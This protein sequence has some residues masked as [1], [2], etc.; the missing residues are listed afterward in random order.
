MSEV[1]SFTVNWHGDQVL[2]NVRT[3]TKYGMDSVMADCVV[4]AK[5]E[6]AWQNRTTILQG[7]I[8]MR[9]AVDSGNDITGYWGAFANN[10]AIFLEEGTARIPKGKYTWLAPAAGKHYPHLSE[11]I[12]AK[13]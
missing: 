10:Y 8:A 4:T 5:S 12:K 2:A 3:A 7:S 11:R 13:L 6:H 1:S 9:P